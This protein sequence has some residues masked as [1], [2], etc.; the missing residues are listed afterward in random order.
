MWRAVTYIPISLCH[1]AYTRT[2]CQRVAVCAP[3][4]SKRSSVARKTCLW[5]SGAFCSSVWTSLRTGSRT[6]TRIHEHSC[7]LIQLGA[8]VTGF[9]RSWGLCGD[10]DT[11]RRES[12]PED[13][14]RIR[15]LAALCAQKDILVRKTQEE[16]KYF[17]LELM[18]REENFN[19][20]FNRNPT[21]GVMSVVKSN[22]A[23]GPATIDA[24]ARGLPPLGAGGG[25]GGPGEPRQSQRQLVPGGGSQRVAGPG[26]SMRLK[27]GS[28]A[29]R[30]RG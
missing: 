5:K 8:F 14:E 17:K 15:Q 30:Q 24:S 3:A 12:R 19:K 21:V 6:G 23:R 7:A 18:N 16:M 28:S 1:C 29:G 20:T 25:G 22:G 9:S 27:R 13:I 4:A 26:G 11:L 10:C 2:A